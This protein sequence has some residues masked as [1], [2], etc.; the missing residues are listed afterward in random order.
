MRFLGYQCPSV[1]ATLVARFDDALVPRSRTAAA[2]I[3]IVAIAVGRK[4]T[5]RTARPGRQFATPPRPRTK[6]FSLEPLRRIERIAFHSASEP[7]AATNPEPRLDSPVHLPV[8]PCC[9]D[10]QGDYHDRRH[11]HQENENDPSRN[12][13][14]DIMADSSRRQHNCQPAAFWSPTLSP[15]LRAS[16]QEHSVARPNKPPAERAA[17]CRGCKHRPVRP[18]CG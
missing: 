17:R 3:L 13:H 5:R 2:V 7:C 8:L 6:R 9:P 15:R 14:A 4:C 11:E 10:E 12:V 1:E 18:P 16:L